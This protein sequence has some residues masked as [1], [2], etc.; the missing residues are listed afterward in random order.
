MEN[1]RY[2]SLVCRVAEKLTLLG[3]PMEIHKF[4]AD[5]WKANNSDKQFGLHMISENSKMSV[6]LQTELCGESECRRNC[7]VGFRFP[8]SL[9]KE[10][11]GFL[12]TDLF[13]ACEPRELFEYNFQIF[14]SG[15]ARCW[16][17]CAKFKPRQIAEELFGALQ[18][19]R[20][21]GKKMMRCRIEKLKEE[22]QE[23]EELLKRTSVL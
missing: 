17:H 23:L 11:R 16:F 6:I 10:E 8:Y 15:M 9:W 22:T 1:K 7:K 5:G 3:E 12:S 19:C 18:H 20:E 2:N 21:V 14:T 4:V 13:K